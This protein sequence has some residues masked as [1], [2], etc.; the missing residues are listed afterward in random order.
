[1]VRYCAKCGKVTRIQSQ[2]IDYSKKYGYSYKL[3]S[4]CD[5]CNVVEEIGI[6]N[7]EKPKKTTSWKWLIVLLILF[8]IVYK[9]N[10]PF[11][12]KDDKGNEPPQPTESKEDYIASCEEYKYKDVLRNFDEYGGKRIKVTLYVMDSPEEGKD[13][14]YVK[15]YVAGTS[16]GL[17]LEMYAIADLR[18][19][20]NPKI[21]N[22][23]TITVYGEI[24]GIRELTNSLNK[25]YEGIVID[26][27]YVEIVEE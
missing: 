12:L 17:N 24:T 14:N 20:K 27:K 7:D 25:T 10:Y 9:T 22:S 11:S 13:D 15:Y 2:K 3:F 26:M 18:Y 23:D 4:I 8:F 21:L 16:S 1:M 19:D 5:N 6:V